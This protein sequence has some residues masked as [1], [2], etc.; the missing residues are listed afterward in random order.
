MKFL[1]RFRFGLLSLLRFAL[2]AGAL[3]AIVMLGPWERLWQIHDTYPEDVDI[4]ESGRLLALSDDIGKVRV[5][6]TQRGKVIREWN[7]LNGK[8]LKISLSPNGQFLVCEHAKDLKTSTFSVWPVGQVTTFADCISPPKDV[9]WFTTMNDG[10]IRW[11]VHSSDS[12]G[13]RCYQWDYRDNSIQEVDNNIPLTFNGIPSCF[14]GLPTPGGEDH[15]TWFGSSSLIE[16]M[17]LVLTW[18]GAGGISLWRK[19][20]DEREPKHFQRPE[21]LLAI[22]TGLWWLWGLLP[23]RRAQAA[24]DAPKAA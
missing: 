4:D 1:S 22:V 11:L 3:L 24:P 6:D 13:K 12:E 2:F 5:W 20:Y 10:T 18:D 15:L 23:K 8:W 16:E 17:D 9:G 19:R 7:H 21:V 14:T